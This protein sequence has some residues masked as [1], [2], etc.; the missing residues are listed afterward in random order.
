MCG[1]VRDTVLVGSGTYANH[2]AGAS[3]TGHGE[4]VMKV[5]L[6]RE[7]VYNIERGD[8]PTEANSKAIMKMYKHMR[9]HGG[10]ISVDRYGVTGLAFNTHH[11]CWASI[12]DG[13]LKYGI[14]P[15]AE[16]IEE[17]GTLKN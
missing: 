4:S 14:D 6:S 16:V 11:M 12:R 5:L 13:F 9:A 8:N 2:S 10:V 15:G 1:R 3:C 17:E 7:V